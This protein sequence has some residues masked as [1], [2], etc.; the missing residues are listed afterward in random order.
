MP[1]KIQLEITV[2]E[3]GGFEL[4]DPHGDRHYAHSERELA[5]V[6]IRLARDPTMP[7]GKRV[8]PTATILEEVGTRMAADNLPEQLVGVAPVFGRVMAEVG[9]TAAELGRRAADWFRGD[10]P[11]PS[12]PN[13]VDAP[14][15]AKTARPPQEPPRPRGPQRAAPNPERDH[16]T[17][18][19]T[20]SSPGR[21]TRRTSLRFPT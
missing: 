6:V 9:D 17:S 14:S 19:T 15:E 5:D 1:H 3:Q 10:P 4:L 11:P 20:A 16:P 18:P 12:E 13:V 2:R 7:Q 21:S 8:T